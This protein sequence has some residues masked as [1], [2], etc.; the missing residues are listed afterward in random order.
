M[1]QVVIMKFYGKMVRNRHSCSYLQH[2]VMAAM[3]VTRMLMETSTVM[4][5]R[6]I[7]G[8][9]KCLKLVLPHV[10]VSTFDN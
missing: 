9:A 2:A 7:T 6:N 5:A 4:N 8:Y 1:I 3:S 10:K